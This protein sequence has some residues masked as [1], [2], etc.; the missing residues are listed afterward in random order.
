MALD[1]DGKVKGWAVQKRGPILTIYTSYMTCFPDGWAIVVDN[2]AYLVIKYPKTPI[3][4][5]ERE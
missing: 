4:R 2:A 5:A 1:F 3:L